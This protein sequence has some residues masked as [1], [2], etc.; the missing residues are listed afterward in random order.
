MELFPSSTFTTAA[1]KGTYTTKT[2]SPLQITMLSR[3]NSCTVK[4]DSIGASVTLL[5]MIKLSAVV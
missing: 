3:T 2:D 4:R 5:R 1:L